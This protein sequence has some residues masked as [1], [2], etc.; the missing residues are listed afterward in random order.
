MPNPPF[1]PL[2]HAKGVKMAS[3]TLTAQLLSIPEQL[4]YPV[5]AALKELPIHLL[6]PIFVAFVGI[7]FLAVSCNAP[8]N[9]P[10]RPASLHSLLCLALISKGGLALC[11]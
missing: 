4:L 3:K 8:P 7:I 10:N 9:Y 11:I 2:S 5:Y 1:P 6:V